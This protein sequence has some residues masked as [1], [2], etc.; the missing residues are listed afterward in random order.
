MSRVVISNILVQKTTNFLSFPKFWLSFHS[1]ALPWISVSNSLNIYFLPRL[2]VADQC[3]HPIGDFGLVNANVGEVL[4]N[5]HHD[6]KWD[7]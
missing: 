3:D 2:V 7:T 1:V 6:G 4:M 5:L